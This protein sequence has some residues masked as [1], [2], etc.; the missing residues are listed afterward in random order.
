MKLKPPY[1]PVQTIIQN[2]SLE[3]WV[4]LTQHFGQ[5]WQ[6]PHPNQRASSPAGTPYCQINSQPQN[7][8][9]PTVLFSFFM[10]FYNNRSLYVQ[11]NLLVS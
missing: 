8:N 10:L 3:L 11:L 5:V 6:N 9:R 2:Q 7:S 4:S 1:Y